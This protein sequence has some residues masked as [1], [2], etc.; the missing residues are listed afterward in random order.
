MGI[1]IIKQGISSVEADAIVNPAN[2]ALQ[3][4]GGVCGILFRECGHRRELQE[5]CNKYGRC[6]TGSAVLTK[7]YDLK[8][9]YIIHAVGPIWRG[10]NNNEAELLY[11]AYK[12]SLNLVKEYGLKSVVFPLISAGIFGYPV[13][14]AWTV[15]LTACNDFSKEY[16]IEI[17]FA[18]IDEKIYNVGQSLL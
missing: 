10:G 7:A 6:E 9:K 17:I 12:S 18:V 1:K 16:D 14:E 5:E 15:A 13:E 11:N 4:G 3:E 2:E 8:A